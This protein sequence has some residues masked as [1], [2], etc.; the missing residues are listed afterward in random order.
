M[1]GAMIFESINYAGRIA[2]GAACSD[3][4]TVKTSSIVCCYGM[5]T[6]VIIGP[7]NY[8]PFFHRNA[9]WRIGHSGDRNISRGTSASPGIISGSISVSL[10]TGKKQAGTA[11]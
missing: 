2:I 6:I 8:G 7:F 10:S 4:S 1:Y 11:K 3:I 5:G 9:G